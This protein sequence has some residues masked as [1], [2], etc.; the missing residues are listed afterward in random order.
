MNDQYAR[1]AQLGER[2]EGYAREVIDS[3]LE[4][5]RVLGPGFLESLYEEA[6]AEELALRGV[7]FRRQ[8]AVAV[9]YKGKPIGQGRLDLLV[10]E[11]LI[12]ELKATDGS[13]PVHLAQVLSYLKATGHPLGLLIN[14][15]VRLLR[16]GVKRVIWSQ[17]TVP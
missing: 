1:H 17:S 13:P 12:V 8:A 9:W 10:A 14:F 15:N 11:Q 6:M 2:L 3:A 5:H 16:Q 4:V 7:P